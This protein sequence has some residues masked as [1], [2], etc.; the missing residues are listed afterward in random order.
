MQP[1]NLVDRAVHSGALRSR[2]RGSSRWGMSRR[3]AETVRTTMQMERA[4]SHCEIFLPWVLS[5]RPDFSS[6]A[7]IPEHGSNLIMNSKGASYTRQDF[8]SL[9]EV[10]ARG[11]EIYHPVKFLE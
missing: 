5:R 10:E 11:L 7:L 3:F 8:L 2:A 6:A 9:A 1:T 4:S